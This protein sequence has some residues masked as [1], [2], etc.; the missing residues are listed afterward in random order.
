MS[1]AKGQGQ[2]TYP[3]GQSP[4]EIR[5]LRIQADVLHTAATRFLFEQAGIG[6][7]MRVLDIGCGAGD[8]S[9][10]AAELVGSGGAV[11]GI[12]SSPV[13]LRAAEVRAAER[14]LTNVSFIEGNLS[15][16]LDTEKL[17]AGGQFDAL[18]GRAVLMYLPDATATLRRFLPLV[19]IGG[20]VAFREVLVGEPLLEAFPSCPLVDSYNAW[21]RE[22]QL[23]AY[24][25]IGVTGLIGL[26]LHQVF[27]DAGL[28]APQ[29]WLHAPLGHS[30]EW[31]GWEYLNHQLQLLAG[32]AAKGGIEVPAEFDPTTMA[33]RVRSQVLERRGVLRIQRGVQAW[34]RKTSTDS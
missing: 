21:Y 7:Q 6:P 16:P 34:T 3:I 22:H 10:L 25:A 17:L 27:Q 24:D 4:E 26:R 23:R 31:D 1:E 12:D 15:A 30:P 2:S 14:G 9:F 20:I 33:D 29:T 11:V 19:R 5:R 8:G 28:P 18:V 32:L 13:A